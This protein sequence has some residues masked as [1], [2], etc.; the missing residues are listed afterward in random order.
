MPAPETKPECMGCEFARQELERLR[1]TREC[2][3]CGALWFYVGEL[4]PRPS[5]SKNCNPE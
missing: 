4:P 2:G 3:T 1:V 5:S